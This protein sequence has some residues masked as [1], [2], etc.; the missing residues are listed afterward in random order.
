[1]RL[2][3]VHPRSLARREPGRG[4]DAHGGVHHHDLQL[5][6]ELCRWRPDS[7]LAGYHDPD[8][9]AVVD[10]RRIYDLRDRLHINAA[11]SCAYE[12]YSQNLKPVHGRRIPMYSLPGDGETV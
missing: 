5:R 4:R 12:K 7:N 8:E 10:F 3:P 2:L 9:L 11:R 1:M 6:L